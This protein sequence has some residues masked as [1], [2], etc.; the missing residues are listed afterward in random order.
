MSRQGKL[1]SQETSRR[2]LLKSMAITASATALGAVGGDSLAKANQTSKSSLI[3]GIDPANIVDE[4]QARELDALSDADIYRQV[5]SIVSR[6][7]AQGINS[8]SLHAPL[9]LMARYGLLPLVEP[10][11]RPLARLQMVASGAAYEAGV[12]TVGTPQ[13]IG[14]F[15]DLT[16]ASREFTRVFNA[17]EADAMEAIVLQIAAQFSTASLIHLLT[18]L[19]LPTLTGASHSHIGLWLLLRHGRMG[20]AGDAS[21]LRAAARRIAADPN[22]QLTSFSGMA[23]QGSKPL[24]QSLVEIESE[25]FAKLSDPPRGKQGTTSLRTLMEAGEANGNADR[26]FGDFIKH[27]LTSEQMDASFRAV[28]RICAHSML[29]D[30][31][32]QAK[33]GWSHCL[34]LPQAA[35]GLSSLNMDRKLALAATLVWISAYRSELSSRRLDFTWMPRKI[36]ESMSIREAL[37]SSPDVAAA[38]VWHADFAE[39]P[40]IIQSLATQASIRNDQHLVKYSRACIDMGSFDPTHKHLYLAAAAYLCALWINESPQEKIRNNLLDGRNTN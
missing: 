18:P 10:H 35:C 38:R 32:N 5:A 15:P 2:Q 23:I 21:L 1:N 24:N 26:F 22:G 37:H 8:F 31:V 7:Q 30:D 25:I 11:E 4:Y 9:E 39:Y 14:P 13:S 29:Q 17:G 20:E 36:D 34:T 16:T 27:D 3:A 40:L 33:F 12:K 19:A 6:P 28:L